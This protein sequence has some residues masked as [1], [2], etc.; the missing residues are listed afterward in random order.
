MLY[1]LILACFLVSGITGLIYQVLWTRMI[2]GIIGSSPFSVT[3]VLA[4]FMAGLGLGSA[5]AGKTVDRVARPEKL[6]RIYGLLELGIGLYCLLLPLLLLLFKPLYAWIYNR[7][8][9]HFLL[10][11]LLTFAGCALLLIIPATF[12]GA[13]LPVLSRFFVNTLSRVGTHVGRL[14]GLN[15]IGSAA[16]S[17]L[18]GFWLINLVGVQGVL[19][20]AVLLNAGIGLL[21]LLVSRRR[22]GWIAP[23][24]TEE[25][26]RPRASR[27]RKP[28]PPAG[29][30]V[31]VGVV[32][33]VFAVTGF[34]AMAYEV[35][36]TRLLGL[37]V[38]PTTYSFTVVLVTFI[39]GLAL[40]SFFF[41]WLGDRV[42]LPAVLL[43]LT[44]MAAALTAL[45]ASQVIGNSQIF[46][47]KLIH[48]HQDSF[49]S[50]YLMKAIVLFGFLFLTT[51]SLGAAFPLVGKI[52]TRSLAA[53]GRSIGYAYAV[54]SI[55][56]VLG[57][58]VA[59]FVLIPFLGKENGLRLVIGLQLAA[60]LG[61]WLVI[62]AARRSTFPR[63]FAL[64][65]PAL[66]G[67]GL[68][69]AFPSW[70]HVML[71]MG[72]YHR[73][74]RPELRDI[75][76]L[77]SLLA[78]EKHFP[79]LKSEK[80]L[81]YGDGIGGFTTV[82]ES[83]GP[84]GDVNYN[85]CNSGKPDA[86]STRDMDTQTLLAHFPLLYHPA[87]DDVLVIGLGS[88]I[89]AGEILH[90]P[91]K[92]LDV[93]E[94]NEQVV[95]ASGFFTP[96][97]NRVLEDPRTRLIVQ[98]GRAHLELANRKYDLVTSEPSNPWMSGI[99]ALYTRDFFEL[100]AARLKPGGMFVQ[101]I[102][103]YQMDWEAFS[104]IG[105]TFASA[106]PRSLLVS[107]NPARPSSFLFVGIRG[108]GGLDAGT[109]EANLAYAARSGNIRLADGRIFQNLIVSDSLPSLFAKGPIHTDNR[110]LLEY[111]APRAMHVMDD[112]IIRRIG[113]A[114]GYGVSEGLAAAI[115]ENQD[116]VGRQVAYAE[117]FLN[118]RGVDSSALQYRVNLAAA[119]PAERERHAA[120]VERFCRL[121]LVTEF[122]A[123]TDPAIR[124]RCYAAQEEAVT[125]R[126]GQAADKAP[127]YSHLG[128]ISLENRRPEKA[129][130]YFSREA[131]L[132]PRDKA[133]R[134]NLGTAYASAGRHAEAARE[135]LRALEIDPGYVQAHVNLG[136]SLASQGRS[137]LGE[138][139]VHFRAALEL[140]PENADT[141][142]HLGTALMAEGDVQPAI[143]HFSRA[144][145]IRPGFPS[146]ENNLRRALALRE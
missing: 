21:C 132:H 73:F 95:E 52:Y 87:P 69:T 53:T 63:R 141:H 118:F 104:M 31:P 48:L 133:A 70:D 81:F 117:Y 55:G 76:W 94:I 36:W 88:G 86:S 128:A 100:V 17:L 64:A 59:G 107:T 139:I 29:E 91:V 43:V 96:W 32:L 22:T 62:A 82:L 20:V 124:E 122:R 97:N 72:K 119:T 8:F 34:C 44:Q 61:A 145:E 60:A 108:E 146:A 11:N 68:M 135:Y 37:L 26:S 49:G 5:V 106:F 140:D 18:C 123:L 114:A 137:R 75:G 3:I 136:L 71:S 47:A 90:Y 80:L 41:G 4:V 1:L 7:L 9:D 129:I 77:E 109:A 54:N 120:N 111:H 74:D 99:A 85:L 142:N 67:F 35:I 33:A 12:M 15:T 27:P 101:W 98:D 2:V 30:V 138:A 40:G 116:D 83:T 125:A 130:D 24:E 103:A 110:P 57:S 51:F 23:Q 38:G 14:Y 13:T 6:I 89:T 93:V 66:L 25:G 143:V 50:L 45:L 144:L 127:L 126:L 46:F 65:L 78:W 39:T 102:P 56:A 131:G 113:S 92:R 105:R 28:A 115:R 84:L 42:K 121:N 10:Y 112:T 79:D 16:G 19:A 58:A 134:N